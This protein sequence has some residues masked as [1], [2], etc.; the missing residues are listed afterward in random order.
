MT[1]DTFPEL[2][3]PVLVVGTLA[4]GLGPKDVEKTIT[5]RIEKYVSATPGRRLRAEH[6]AQQP[7]GRLRLAQVGHRPQLGA[8]AGAAAGGVRDVGGAEVARRAAA[9]RAAV[10]PVERAG[11]PGRRLGRRAHGAAALRLRAQQHRA[12]PR[13]HPRRRERVDQ[14]RPAAPDQRRRRSGARA[15]A[16]RDLER[17]RRGG[18]AVERAACRR[19]SSSRRASTPTS[20][21]TRSRRASADI[22]DA[23][24]KVQSARTP[25]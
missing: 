20:T 7:V 21:P 5:W 23:I 22:G 8:D 13:G 11:D 12:D 16:R 6:V 19:A 1:V 25:C 4:P 18:R 24:V 17:R 10:R 14:R 3:P 2:T 15:G 9:V